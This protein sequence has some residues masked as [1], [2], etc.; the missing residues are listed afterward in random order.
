LISARFRDVPNI[1]TAVLQIAMFM[2][3]VFWRPEGIKTARFVLD[4]NPFYYMLEV[5]RRP[6]LGEPVAPGSWSYLVLLAAIGWTVAFVVF[7]TE[8]RKLVHYL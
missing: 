3:P 1:V 6:L 2:T 5:C 4:S 8:R 7:A